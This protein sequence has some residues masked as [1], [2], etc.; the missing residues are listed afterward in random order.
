[1]GPG[2]H[3]VQDGSPGTAFFKEISLFPLSL[4]SRSLNVNKGVSKVLGQSVVISLEKSLREVTWH[5]TL[6][7]HNH[8][9]Y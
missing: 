1:M 6:D 3:P 2:T 8:N 7:F 4:P 9:T 5:L